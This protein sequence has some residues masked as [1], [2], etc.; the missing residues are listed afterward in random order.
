VIVKLDAVTLSTVPE[1][2]P[3]A[4][5]ER[6]FEPAPPPAAPRAAIAEVNDALVAVADPPLDVALTM[7]YAPPPIAIAIT[8]APT[9]SRLVILRENM[10]IASFVR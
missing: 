8:V 10:F 9:A 6:A 4:G 5:P 3:A 2:P 7:P 1:E